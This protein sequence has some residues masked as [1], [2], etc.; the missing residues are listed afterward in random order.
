MTIGEITFT[1]NNTQYELFLHPHLEKWEG[2][3]Y[4]LQRQDGVLISENI[5]TVA[6]L[7]EALSLAVC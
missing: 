7:F 5:F 4:C 2:A 6:D 3:R 1:H